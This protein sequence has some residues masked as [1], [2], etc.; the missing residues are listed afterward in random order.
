[1]NSLPF[2]TA[3][4]DHCELCFLPSHIWI[5]IARVFYLM[6]AFGHFCSFSS[7]LRYWVIFQAKV[8]ELGCLKSRFYSTLSLSFFLVNSV[9]DIIVRKQFIK[10]TVYYLALEKVMGNLKSFYEFFFFP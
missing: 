1:M 9:T 6:T 4:L 8:P 7:F 2:V 10:F 3:N 5:F